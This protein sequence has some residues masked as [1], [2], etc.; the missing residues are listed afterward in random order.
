MIISV[1]FFSLIKIIY[2]SIRE[3]AHLMTKIYNVRTLKSMAMIQQWT[4]I[5]V[6]IKI[7]THD[8]H[9]APLMQSNSR[10]SGL[11]GSSQSKEEQELLIIRLTLMRQEL[12]TTCL[13]STTST[14]GSFMA[15]LRMQVMSKPYTF[16][17]PGKHSAAVS[18]VKSHRVS[19]D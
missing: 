16:S 3:N 15:T 8:G 12:V 14:S 1:R 10:C 17:H 13:G 5:S 7:T 6:W 4:N 19:Q 11:E 9:N 18:E 2:F